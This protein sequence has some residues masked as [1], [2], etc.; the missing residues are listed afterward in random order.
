VQRPTIELGPITLQVTRHY[1]DASSLN[2]LTEH[3]QELTTML[4]VAV[5]FGDDPGSC[6]HCG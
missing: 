1:F 6:F 3:E 5:E 2:V 4:A